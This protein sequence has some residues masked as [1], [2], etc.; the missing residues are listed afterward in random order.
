MSPLGFLMN[1]RRRGLA[2]ALRMGAEHGY[3]CVG[4]CYMYMFVMLA[5]AATSLPAIAL[6][7]VVVTLEKVVVKGA[8]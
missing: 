7:A 1:H 2:G 3:F 8:A 6:L 5:V 4:C